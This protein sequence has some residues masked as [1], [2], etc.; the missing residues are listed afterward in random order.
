M[1]AED[2]CYCESNACRFMEGVIY[3]V[4]NGRVGLD[5]DSSRVVIFMMSR[6]YRVHGHGLL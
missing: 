4:M 2:G 5:V 6:W 1:V 3:V